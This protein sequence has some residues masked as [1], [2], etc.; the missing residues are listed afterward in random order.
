MGEARRGPAAQRAT[1]RT[2]LDRLGSGMLGLGGIPIGDNGGRGGA[3]KCI[4]ER[5][6]AKTLVLGSGGRGRR[7]AVSNGCRLSAVCGGQRGY[8]CD[9][10]EKRMALRG[11]MGSV[12][13]V[14]KR[15]LVWLDRENSAGR[16][17]PAWGFS[18]LEVCELVSLGK[19]AFINSMPESTKRPP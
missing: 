19:L 16:R 10:D 4:C 6:R 5:K 12:Q 14:S 3:T 15:Q 8:R 13:E 7:F 18:I 11:T 1:I 9:R 2:A 17:L